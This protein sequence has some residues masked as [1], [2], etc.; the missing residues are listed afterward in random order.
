MFF[1]LC[2][3]YEFELQTHVKSALWV[4]LR[5]VFFLPVPPGAS[6]S[7]QFSLSAV[8]EDGFTAG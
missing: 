1:K 8:A 5:T 7:Q 6:V 4:S 2:R 3:W